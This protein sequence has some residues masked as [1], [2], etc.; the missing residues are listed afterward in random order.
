MLDSHLTSAKKLL[1]DWEK[2]L[3]TLGLETSMESRSLEFKAWG[4]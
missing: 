2:G 4:S 1:R 3:C